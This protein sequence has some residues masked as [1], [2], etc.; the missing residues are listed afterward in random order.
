MKI[1]D[2]MLYK[3]GVKYEEFHGERYPSTTIKT[4]LRTT[5][6]KEVVTE[7]KSLETKMSRNILNNTCTKSCED[8]RDVNSDRCLL[9]SAPLIACNWGKIPWVTKDL[10]NRAID[11]QI[12]SFEGCGCRKEFIDGWKELKV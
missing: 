2:L 8:E 12:K 4:P 10:H 6:T 9:C 1:I 11:L 3:L 7:L 5:T